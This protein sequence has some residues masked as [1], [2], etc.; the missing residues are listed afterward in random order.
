MK[1]DK[2]NIANTDSSAAGA[3]AVPAGATETK[4]EKFKRFLRSETFSGYLFVLP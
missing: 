3:V 2:K 1:K 4:K